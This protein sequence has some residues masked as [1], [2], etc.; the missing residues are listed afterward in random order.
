MNTVPCLFSVRN[1]F[2]PLELVFGCIPSPV[3]WLEVNGVLIG[4]WIGND[5][6]IPNSAF[7]FALGTFDGRPLSV[8]RVCALL[9]VESRL[10]AQRTTA[11]AKPR[12]DFLQAISVDPP[13]SVCI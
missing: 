2:L 11:E 4:F 6:Q 7:P 3:F 5:D 10:S 8:I 1:M 13:A 12:D 9:V